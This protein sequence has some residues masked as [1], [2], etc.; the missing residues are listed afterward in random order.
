M[1]NY[2]LMTQICFG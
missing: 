2:T 1:V